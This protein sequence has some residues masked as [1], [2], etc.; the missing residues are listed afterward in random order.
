LIHILKERR[1][2]EQ[3]SLNDLVKV[4]EIL[5]RAP[6]ANRELQLAGSIVKRRLSGKVDFIL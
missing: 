1:A 3:L 4:I 6:F 2:V 5:S